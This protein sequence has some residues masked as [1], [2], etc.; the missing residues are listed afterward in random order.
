MKKAKYISNPFI[1]LSGEIIIIAGIIT[2]L[3]IKDFYALML[4]ICV[5]IIYIIP[6][7]ILRKLMFRKMIINEEGLTIYYRNSLVKQLFW[8]DIKDAQAII[9][10]QGGRILFSDKALYTGKER[11]RNWNCIFV[12]LKTSFAIELYKYKDKIPV[13]INN[14][15]QLDPIIQEKLKKSS[16]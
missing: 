9:T 10:A 6:I 3:V 16:K 11:W 12:N 5:S 1:Y 14:F 7:I 4:C 13:Q 8:K 2:T 15:E